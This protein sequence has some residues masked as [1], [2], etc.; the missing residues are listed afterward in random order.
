M[1]LYK[2]E[3]SNAA[4]AAVEK[5]IAADASGATVVFIDATEAGLAAN[6]E[7]GLVSPGWWSYQTYTDAAGKTRHKAECLVN[8]QGP[9]ANASE[10]QA[11][12]AIAADVAATIAIAVQP[13][14]ASV[15]VGDAMTLSVTATCTPPGNS[16]VLTF[17]WQKK[18]GN[19][20]KNISGA[21]AYQY[22]VATYAEANA[23]V[24]R[25]KINS[26]NGASELVSDTATVTTA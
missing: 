25:V 6:R 22:Q 4:K 15:T 16:S 5:T 23:G 1:S 2:S 26:T 17:Q 13:A 20:F 10:T 11:D 9:E 24:Y 3:D 8:I 19:R 21:T 7:R 12:D 14:D 18:E